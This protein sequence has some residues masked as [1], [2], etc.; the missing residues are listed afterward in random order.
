MKNITVD[1]AG[2]PDKA[3]LHRALAQA[4]SF[5]D[6]YGKN[7]DAMYDCLMD[8]RQDTTLALLHWDALGSFSGGFRAVLEE[9][10]ND[11]PH[12][13]VNIH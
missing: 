11:N 7:L 8:I 3:A 6:Y 4:L 1:C 12:L 2:I 9:A 5:P 10:E 13:I